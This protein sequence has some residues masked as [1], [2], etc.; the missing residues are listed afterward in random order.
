MTDRHIS[1]RGIIIHQGKLL[2]VRLNN[3][4]GALKHETP[5]WCLPGGGLEGGETLVDGMIREMMEETGITP[6][7]GN[8][9]YIQQFVAGSK[10]YLEFFFHIAN[11]NDYLDVDLSKSTHGQKEIAEIGFVD[12]ALVTV[13]PEFLATEDITAAVEAG[14]PT[15]IISQ[16]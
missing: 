2:L 1:V 3:Y 9:L 7:V 13:L 5:Y 4:K 15:K 12:P 11:S 8:L 6:V 16:L 10:E 14:E